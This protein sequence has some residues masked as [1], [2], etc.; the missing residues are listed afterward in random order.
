MA[1]IENKP[2][3]K[4]AKPHGEAFSKPFTESVNCMDKLQISVGGIAKS[5]NTEVKTS[6]IKQRGH[7]AATK[8]FTSRGPM[9]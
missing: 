5:Q 2:A 9:A 3:E 6:G 7:G 1:K 4:Y 8:G